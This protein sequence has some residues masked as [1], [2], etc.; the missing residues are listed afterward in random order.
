MSFNSHTHKHFKYFL[1][2]QLYHNLVLVINKA[3]FYQFFLF[4]AGFLWQVNFGM[5]FAVDF[6]AMV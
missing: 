3:D 4:R 5:D 6:N 2:W 1:I